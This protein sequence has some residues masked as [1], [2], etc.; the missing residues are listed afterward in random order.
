[1][2]IAQQILGVLGAV[3][4]RPLQQ[5]DIASR[6]GANQATV[7][8]TV[9]EL[10]RA[11]KIHVADYFGHPFAPRFA[12]VPTNISTAPSQASETLRERQAFGNTASQ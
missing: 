5:I 8:R 11:G 12:I 3:G 4:A 1:M 2:T 6:I 7:R 9:Q 10:T